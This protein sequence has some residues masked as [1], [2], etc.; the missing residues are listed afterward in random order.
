M[1][2]RRR[3]DCRVSVLAEPAGGGARSPRRSWRS[4]GTGAARARTAAN[5][6]RSRKE[7]CVRPRPRG[8]R[9]DEQERREHRDQRCGDLVH[10]DVEGEDVHLPHVQDHVAQEQPVVDSAEQV[11]ARARVVP[12]NPGLRN[13]RPGPNQPAAVGPP[14]SS[15]SRTRSAA[16]RRQHSHSCSS[17]WPGPTGPGR[18]SSARRSHSR[19]PRL[20]RLPG[21]RVSW[22]SSSCPSVGVTSGAAR[23]RGP[24]C[25]R[26]RLRGGGRGLGGRRLPR[27][28]PR[29]S[30]AAVPVRTRSRSRSGQL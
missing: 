30:R 8:W 27:Q 18:W 7:G 6:A 11:A 13:A 29:R 21:P 14:V 17:R 26:D 9:R 2:G 25:G 28:L 12:T 1:R 5:R 24:L 19:I 20:W 23:A 22:W 3:G 10:G 4:A 15:R 16:R